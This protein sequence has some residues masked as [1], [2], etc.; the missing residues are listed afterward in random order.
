MRKLFWLAAAVW[1]ALNL[2]TL[3]GYPA[4]W[5]DEILFAD[6]AMHLARG[7]GFVSGAWFN[8]PNNE[9]W[10]G[11]TPL[12][13]FVL[14]GWLKLFGVSA[15]LVRSF[16]LAL[17]SA[18]LVMNWFCLKQFASDSVRWVIV[19]A[20]AVCEPLAF[21]ERA[22]RP[23]SM[24]VF[25]LSA[26][27][28]VFVQKDWRWRSPLLW[29]L[30][31]LALP[32]ALQYTA[33]V[34]I[35]AILLQLWFRP[36]SRRDILLWSSGVASGALALAIVYGTHHLLKLFFEVTFVSQHSSVGRIL[37]RLILGH[38]NTPF[39]WPDIVSASL[40]DYAT[41]VLVIC[42]I[43]VWLSAKRQGLAAAQ[44]IASFGLA[45][46]VLIPLAIQLLGKYPI[47]YTYMGAIP[48]TIAVLLAAGQLD[49]K[50]QAIGA[51]IVALLFAGGA[52]RIYWTGWQQGVQTV[53]AAQF[54]AQQSTIV[55]DYA[56][57]YQLTGKT[58]ELLGVD[59]GGGKL[60]RHYPAEQA[61]RVSELIVRDSRFQEVA[62]KVGGRWQR[63]G[64]SQPHSARL[65]DVY[66]SRN[67]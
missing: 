57:Y 38:G 6:P 47:Y 27:A 13:S 4:P 15:F 16:S 14:A 66:P 9:L 2:L 20:L 61:A 37:Q 56:A 67:H 24:S 12:Y 26:T 60:L 11:Y 3:T 17:V 19:L 43:V 32:S 49:K 25:L 35:L 50:G 33:D 23:D 51:T 65:S 53:D 64:E 40:R 48:A 10:A 8:Q 21:L 46:A 54:A 1:L 18:S 55:A 7:D 41:P 62:N 36:L 5:V 28:L 39:V 44:K 29:L 34:V 59:Y 42:G 31:A 58:R 22:G 30:G 52:G 63:I 45:C